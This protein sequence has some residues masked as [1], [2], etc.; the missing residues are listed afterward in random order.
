[1]WK[2][3][4][5]LFGS[6]EEEQKLYHAIATVGTLLLEIGEVGKKFY[7]NKP[8]STTA[9]TPS[10]VEDIPLAEIHG[11]PVEENVEAGNRLDENK[12]QNI[13]NVN[14]ISEKIDCLNVTDTGLKES[15]EKTDGKSEPPS[16]SSDMSSSCFAP[17]E[18]TVS[19]ASS[20]VDVDWS[21]SFEQF[22]A[23]MLTEPALVKYFENQTDLLEAVSK[24]RNRRMLM[25]QSSPP[26]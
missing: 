3:L 12:D 25:R 15:S 13:K 24:T 1:M 18:R 16:A 7:L 19:T 8:E 10:E 9:G 11:E 2:T 23:S 17:R 6:H 20:K 22:L 26:I 4:Y 5:D 21:I 14:D